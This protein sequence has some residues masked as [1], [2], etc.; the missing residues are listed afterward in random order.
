VQAHAAREAHCDR[1]LLDER[2]RRRLTLAERQQDLARRDAE[3]EGG[4]THGIV[5]EDQ[6]D[7]LTHHH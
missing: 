6:L 3:D 5:V 4:E 1:R 7:R 2:V